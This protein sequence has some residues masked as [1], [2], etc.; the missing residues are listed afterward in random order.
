L[1]LISW[2]RKKERARER[3]RERERDEFTKRIAKR[4]DF[5][6]LETSNLLENTYSRVFEVTDS[7]FE[8]MLGT[9]LGEVS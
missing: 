9:P 7:M 2:E 1:L 8:L 3:E 5:L 4:M 6:K